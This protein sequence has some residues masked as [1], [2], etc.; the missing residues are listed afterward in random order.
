MLLKLAGRITGCTDWH[1]APRFS[2][3][4]ARE[5]LKYGPDKWFIINFMIINLWQR[6]WR[7]KQNTCVNEICWNGTYRRGRSRQKNCNILQ[8]KK[9]NERLGQKCSRRLLNS[10]WTLNVQI[11]AIKC[12]RCVTV[13]LRQCLHIVLSPF[14]F[15]W[16]GGGRGKPKSRHIRFKFHR[17]IDSDLLLDL[18]KREERKGWWDGNSSSRFPPL[19]FHARSARKIYRLELSFVHDGRDAFVTTIPWNWRYTSIPATKP[20]VVMFSAASTAPP[21]AAAL[22]SKTPKT[23]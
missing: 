4:I 15:S 16:L 10:D 18:C 2:S 9:D 17:S 13:L 6:L 14:S 21:S 8:K 20:T 22:C 3:S 23:G 12:R 19:C 11:C 5:W 1:R 7:T